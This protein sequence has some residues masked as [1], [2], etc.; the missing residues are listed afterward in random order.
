M[1][2]NGLIINGK[3]YTSISGPV[4]FVLMYPKIEMY[5]SWIVKGIKLPVFMFLGDY[6]DSGNT[7]CQDTENGVSI[8][9]QEWYS[10]LD[11]LS[12]HATPI[13]Y[14]IE[15]YLGKPKV[16][17]FKTQPIRWVTK[18]FFECIS[19]RNTCPTSNIEWMSSEIR[20]ETSNSCIECNLN[21]L[22]INVMLLLRE[23]ST[24]ISEYVKCIKESM[25][26][27]Q[28][29]TESIINT[30]LTGNWTAFLD[31]LLRE[32]MVTKSI[33]CDEIVK[34]KTL[35]KFK[36]WREQF[37]IMY[38]LQVD[39]YEPLNKTIHNYYSKCKTVLD[40]IQHVI[41]SEHPTTIEFNTELL[42]CTDTLLGYIVDFFL[43]IIDFYTLMTIFASDS[44]NPSLVVYNAGNKHI[45]LLTKYLQS[46]FLGTGDS[47]VYND[48]FPK[49][50][51]RKVQGIPQKCIE[52][53]YTIDLNKILKRYTGL[54]SGANEMKKVLQNYEQVDIHAEI[55]RLKSQHLLQNQH[56]K[57]K[58]L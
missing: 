21:F 30:V 48:M 42:N 3:R 46:Y 12:T 25:S 4:G 45:K 34:N 47:S 26:T 2:N 19:N 49:I 44:K 53:K 5:Y 51:S 57:N 13:R 22:L 17:T 16:D 58:L 32:E 54:E 15:T 43:P 6:H 35:N 36:W 14:Y 10:A 50:W 7:M 38:N 56:I 31:L 55:N 1:S 40:F 41:T 24:D 37:E 20:Y 11:K 18:N 23:G 33:L 27:L 52:I 8:T 9:S 29:D 39:E 28:G